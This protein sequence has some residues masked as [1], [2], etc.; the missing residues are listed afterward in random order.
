MP[1]LAVSGEKLSDGGLHVTLF[2]DGEW[3]HQAWFRA[4][5]DNDDIVKKLA[6]LAQAAKDADKEGGS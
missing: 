6:Q 2:V 4:S 3:N 5:D 1:G